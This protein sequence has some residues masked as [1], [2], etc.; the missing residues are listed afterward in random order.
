MRFISAIAAALIGGIALLA[1]APAALASTTVPVSSADG[2]VRIAHLSPQA[3]A[4]DMYLYPFGDP[5]APTVLR[6]VAYG[7][8]SPYVQL[9][10]GEYT[11]AMRGLSA[12]SSSQ[13]ALTVSF[14]VSPQTAYTLAALGPDP[15]LRVVVLEAAFAGYGASGRNGGWVTAALPGSRARYAA[16]PRGAQGVRDLE[17]HLMVAGELG[18]Q[19]DVLEHQVHCEAD[20][21]AAV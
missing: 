15:G 10:P 4:M 12:S 20:V 16:H 3:P 6:D 8:V 7:D 9:A 5:G 2:W 11:V 21:A 14:M 17:R 1:G 19:S 18:K 13:P